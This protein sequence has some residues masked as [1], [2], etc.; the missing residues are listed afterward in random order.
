MA[1]RVLF[2]RQC[3]DGRRYMSIVIRAAAMWLPGS[4]DLFEPGRKR[5]VRVAWCDLDAVGWLHNKPRASA[6]ERISFCL[7]FLPSIFH[8]ATAAGILLYAVKVCWSPEGKK[9]RPR[10]ARLRLLILL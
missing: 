1:G 9:D 6:I 8:E 2:Q 4:N 5:L 3:H 10:P 7:F